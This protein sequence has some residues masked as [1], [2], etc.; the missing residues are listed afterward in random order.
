MWRIERDPLLR[1]TIL[2]VWTLDRAPD[3]VRL[4]ATLEKTERL[5]PRLR[6]RVV[7]D[8]LGVSPPRWE[9]DPYFDVNYHVRTVRVPGAGTMRDFLDMAAPVA[10]QAFDK[11]RPLWELYCVE[12][13]EGGRAGV[14]L[15]L[16]HAMSDGVDD[17][18]DRGSGTRGRSTAVGR[19]QALE[20]GGDRT[21]TVPARRGSYTVP[22]R[23]Q[24]ENRAASAVRRADGTGHPLTAAGGGRPG[25]GCAC[26][27]VS[28]PMVA[29]ANAGLPRPRGAA[30]RHAHTPSV[31]CTLNDVFVAAVAGSPAIARGADRPTRRCA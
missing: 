28:E 8:P 15:K 10:M 26:R 16:H 20:H 22:R 5:V 11:D 24:R 2:C 29:V 14:L 12:G 7:S 31:G 21:A 25:V 19:R 1:S 6:Q 18:H 13:L 27:P 17:A 9:P 30:R 3:R 23:H 4:H